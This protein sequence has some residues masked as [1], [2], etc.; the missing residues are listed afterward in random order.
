MDVTHL[1]RV[2]LRTCTWLSGTTTNPWGLRRMLTCLC[3]WLWHPWQC[4][5][6]KHILS[7][8][9]LNPK[10]MLAK[11]WLRMTSNVREGISGLVAVRGARGVRRA[12]CVYRALL[13]EIYLIQHRWDLVKP[14]L[15]A[16]LSW[17][18]EHV[19]TLAEPAPGSTVSTAHLFAI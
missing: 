16:A 6:G 12:T 19:Y 15:P 1:L 13:A 3:G 7:L 4:M 9:E 14:H 2:L 5:P 8:P 18:R 17:L 10:Q 11:H